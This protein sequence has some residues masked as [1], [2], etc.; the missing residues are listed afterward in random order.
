MY[1]LALS[2]EGQGRAEEAQA[3]K[4]RFAGVWRLA[5]VELASSVL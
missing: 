2:L 3:V 4:D 1:G 5:D